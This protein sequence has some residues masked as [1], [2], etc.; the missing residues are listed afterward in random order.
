MLIALL[1]ICMAAQ[2]FLQVDWALLAG[3][4]LGFLLTYLLERRT[5]AALHR[6]ELPARSAD[7]AR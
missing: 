7:P 1:V 6:G 5:D 4:G 3:A 2:T